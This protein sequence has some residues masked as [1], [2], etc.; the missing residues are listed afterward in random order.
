MKREASL[1][2]CLH[3]LEDKD[4]FN[5]AKYEKLYPS[6]SAPACVYGTPKIHKFSSRNLFPKLRSIVSSIGT[7]ITILPVFFVIFRHV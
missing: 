7:L 5:E 4:L 1:R 2:C 6:G 3:Q